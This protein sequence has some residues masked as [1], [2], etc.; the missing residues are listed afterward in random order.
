MRRL[1]SVVLS[2]SLGLI[3]IAASGLVGLASGKPPSSDKLPSQDWHAMGSAPCAWFRAITNPNHSLNVERTILLLRDFNFSC[4]AFPIGA[5]P[6]HDWQNFQQLLPA[7]QVAH[8]DVWP[9]LIPPTEGGNSR[10]YNTDYVKWMQVLAK[11][12]LKY[13]NLRGANIDDLLI[14]GNKKVFTH[15]YLS[16]IYQAKQKINPRFLFVPTVYELDPS[17]VKRLEGCVDGVWFWWMNL[18]RGMGLTSFLV[19]ARVVVGKKFPVYAGVYAARTSWHPEGEPTVRAFMGSMQAACKYS[20][21]VVVWNLSLGVNDPLLQIASS[22][23]PGGTAALA[24]KCGQARSSG[25]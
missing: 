25:E 23:A 18:E 7:A 5:T 19:D 14:D 11:L 9:V 8:I 12:S 22:Y 21:G 15:E 16:Q 6:P 20:D 3:L 24:G 13:P 1:T 17:V 2:T 10:P 4:V